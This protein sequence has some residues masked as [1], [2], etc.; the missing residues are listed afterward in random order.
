MK[1]HLASLVCAGLLWPGVPALFAQ[2]TNSSTNALPM[3]QTLRYQVAVENDRALGEHAL[4]PPGLKEKMRLTDQ[5]RAELKPL[6]AEFTK[7][8]DEYQSANQ[9]RIDAAVEAN[10]LARLSKSTAQ[11]VAARR[12]LHNVWA[13]LQPDRVAAVK[14]IR[15]LLT[16]D[17]ILILDDPAN[18]W[19]E[20]HG[21][22]AN[23]PSS[24]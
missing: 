22:E 8:S 2:S 14:L 10:R 4:L 13:G 6:E 12:Q 7:T 3:N 23:D 19:R 11:L 24:N 21:S 9:P 16:P 15:P 5:Q 17:Q 1:N 20:S 18:Q